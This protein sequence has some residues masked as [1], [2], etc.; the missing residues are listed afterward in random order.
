MAK[1]TKTKKSA[2]GRLI[3]LD[4]P[5]GAGKSTQV[6]LLAERLEQQ[7]LRVQLL[8]EPGGTSA[9]EEIRKL[10]LEQRQHD[11]SPLAETFLFQAARAQLIEAVIKPTLATGTWIIC[12]RFTLST[13]VYQGL[14]G[15]VGRKPIE[16]LSETATAGVKPDRYIVLWVP[17]TTGIERRAARANDRMESKGDA[18]L[19]AVSKGFRSEAKKC[20]KRY[21]FVEGT[22]PVETVRERIWKKVEPLLP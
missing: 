18:F 5:D 20:P 12:D 14:A 6:K 19:S 21:Q 11:L 22:A 9:G 16:V 15:K 4:G 8:R 7:G 2:R 10:V 1:K 17:L 13:L 3:V